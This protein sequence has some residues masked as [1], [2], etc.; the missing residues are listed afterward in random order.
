M[1]EPENFV[2]AHL[3]AT[4]EDVVIRALSRISNEGIDAIE[5]AFDDLRRAGISPS[6][7]QAQS[8]LIEAIFQLLEALE[9][10]FSNA[11]AYALISRLDAE[12]AE[13]S[14]NLLRLANFPDG[15]GHIM[16]LADGTVLLLAALTA[17]SGRKG[18]AEQFLVTAG[19]TRTAKDFR[20][21]VFEL[22]CRLMGDA[23]LVVEALM[24]EVLDTLDH[25]DLWTMLPT[26]L[27]LYPDIVQAFD[28]R[29]EIELLFK[30]QARI[31]RELCLA[32]SGHPE[33]ALKRIEPIA[34]T[35]SLLTLAQGAI[36]HIRSLIDPAN[37][38][39]DLSDRFCEIPFEV[40]DV[41]DGTSHLCCS[42]WVLPS[43]GNLAEQ[44]WEDVWNSDVALD[45]RDS[46]LDG[47]FR[48]C[49]KIACPFIG[50]HQLPSKS[51]VAARSDHWRDIIENNKV[52]MDKGPH[53]VN[54]AYDPTCNLSCPSCRSKKFAADAE[55]RA[56]YD[57]LQEE[58]VL[59]LL[60]QTKLVF[61]TG[62]GD[63]FASK[64]FRRLMERLGPEDYPDLRFQIMTN[65]MLFTRR[66]WERFPALH[67]RV[68][69]LRISLDAATG[70]TH[71]L[72]RRGARWHVMEE[73][74]AFASELRAKGLIDRLDLTFVVQ[75]DNYRE[76]G[77]AVDLAHHYGADSMGFFRLTNW[78]TFTPAQY[79]SKAIFMPLHPDHDRF[80]ETMQ[81]PRLRD[82][83][84]ALQELSQFMQPVPA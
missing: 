84:A 13:E 9:Q 29:I 53:R 39:Y 62:S 76:M 46:I 32:A 75:A 26:V 24:I 14:A 16:D 25:P 59:P 45:I 28:R 6:D 21:A 71:E 42:N 23:D 66:E 52:R 1:Q 55:T 80:L 17:A 37:P 73:N 50:G 15:A 22:R 30:L 33:E 2:S 79:A 54:L 38:V 3:S 48:Y 51:E 19:H 74:L 43:V 27:N 36:F 18:D 5:L 56:R 7:A 63:P 77:D 64:N 41:L 20:S 40:L 57:K 67:N 4:D 82:P 60:R 70:P 8:V 68:A 69:F 81:D 10:N 31:L 49:N 65:G 11:D 12:T 78:G 58:A 72:L 34:I 83:I 44:H 61:V 47:S 35:N